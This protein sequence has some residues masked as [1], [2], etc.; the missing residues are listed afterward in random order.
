MRGRKSEML[1][2]P[3]RPSARCKRQT[4]AAKHLGRAF[5]L[6]LDTRREWGWDCLVASTWHRAHPLS[7]LEAKLL[8][9]I[10][11]VAWNLRMVKNELY[12]FRQDETF[13]HSFCLHLP[14]AR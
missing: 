11:V 8:S 10:D 1:T 9:I 7:A 3:Y 14:H 5:E 12:I 4:S 13:F 6:F 2:D